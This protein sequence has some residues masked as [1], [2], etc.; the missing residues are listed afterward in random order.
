MYKWG[1]LFFLFKSYT[2]LVAHPLM[3]NMLVKF[4]NNTLTNIFGQISGGQ[5]LTDR[6]DSLT[7]S[8]AA[9][10]GKSVGG[11]AGLVV[12][13]IILFIVVRRNLEAAERLLRQSYQLLTTLTSV[14]RAPPPPAPLPTPP[15]RRS[16]GLNLTDE[17]RAVA[18]WNQR[19]AYSALH[20]HLYSDVA[21]VVAREEYI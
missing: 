6:P 8:H 14:F 16:M 17:E 21:T 2:L 20:C 5:N 12:S 9:L 11:A 13:L 10:L 18:A 4:A 7:E 3:P 1:P 15:P 19:L